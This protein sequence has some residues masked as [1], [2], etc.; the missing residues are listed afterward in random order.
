MSYVSVYVSLQHTIATA[1]TTS[2]IRE[3]SQYS[4]CTTR[5]V[6]SEVVLKVAVSYV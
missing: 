2:R 1:V 6:H 3:H 4:G 5:S